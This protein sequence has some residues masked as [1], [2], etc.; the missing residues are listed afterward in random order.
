MSEL[1]DLVNETGEIV[2]RDVPRGYAEHHND[3]HMQI[4][5]AVVFNGLGQVLVHQRAATKKVNPGDIDHICG[6]LLAGESPKQAALR[7]ADEEVGVIINDIHIVSQGLN[8]Y[9]RYRYLVAGKSDQEPNIQPNSTEVA[10]ARYCYPN[11]LIEAGN[12]NKMGFVDEFFDDMELAEKFL[13]Q[14]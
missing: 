6:G 5:I 8:S 14:L 11:E 1:I 9:G 13:S 10:W 12:L 2:R 3:L 7:E 4:I